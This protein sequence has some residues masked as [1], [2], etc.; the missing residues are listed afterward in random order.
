MFYRQIG[1]AESMLPISTYRVIL[2]APCAQRRDKLKR[3]VLKPT[4]LPISK[5]YTLSCQF[6]YILFMINGIQV[7]VDPHLK[8][9]ELH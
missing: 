6:L 8:K 4:I 3:P 1:R 7:L 5:C 9:Y 2:I